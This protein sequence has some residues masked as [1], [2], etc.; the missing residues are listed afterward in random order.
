MPLDKILLVAQVACLGIAGILILLQQRG[1]G[2]SSVLGGSD[3]IY[4]T[5]R[6]VEKWVMVT[7]VVLIIAFCVL[8][9]SDLYVIPS[10]K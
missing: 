2:L 6:G 9:I 10:F 3:Q 4:M 8:R 1:V 7:T 5:R